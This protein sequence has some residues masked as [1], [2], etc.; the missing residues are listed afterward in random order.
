[1]TTARRR[2]R[3][4]YRNHIIDRFFTDVGAY[5]GTS[6]QHVVLDEVGAYMVAGWLGVAIAEVKWRKDQNE[7]RLPYLQH[8]VE[9]NEIGNVLRRYARAYEHSVPV[10]KVEA[11][12]YHQFGDYR[13]CPDAYFQYRA[14]DQSFHG[15]WEHHRGTMTPYQFR[16]EKVPKYRAFL[17]SREYLKHYPTFPHVF[18]SCYD[19]DTVCDLKEAVDKEGAG[20][21][22]WHFST[23]DLIEQGWLQEIWK[24]NDSDRLVSITEYLTPPSES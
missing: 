14:G 16:V 9:I 11:H 10:W 3:V 15:F 23:V 12:N 4:L 20:G 8:T 1:L 21:V 6:E 13:F 18:V 5:N 24:V 19:W 17:E 7:V 22:L 2:L